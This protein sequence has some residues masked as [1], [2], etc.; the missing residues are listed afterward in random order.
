MRFDRVSDWGSASGSNY[1]IVPIRGA[2]DA[3]GLGQPSIGLQEGRRL[4]L[5]DKAD[6]LLGEM[7]DRNATRDVFLCHAHIVFV[8]GDVNVGS[9]LKFFRGANTVP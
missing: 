3:H 6:C 4:P 1:L 5:R 9:I 7:V 8:T 2:R